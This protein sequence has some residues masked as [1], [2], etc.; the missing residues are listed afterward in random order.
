MEQQGLANKDGDV[1]TSPQQRIETAPHS[2][3]TEYKERSPTENSAPT[4]FRAP[5]ATDAAGAAARDGQL[6]QPLQGPW[7]QE[8]SPKQQQNHFHKSHASS[9]LVPQKQNQFP[10]RD[11]GFHARPA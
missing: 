4:P 2:I 5:P 9:Y 7:E 11:R 10:L 3:D 6:K 1:A 8:M